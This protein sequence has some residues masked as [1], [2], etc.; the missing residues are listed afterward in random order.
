MMSPSIHSIDETRSADNDK[1]LKKS[2][3]SIAEVKS[4]KNSP[5]TKH[6]EFQ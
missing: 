2:Y 4:T 1:I 5:H 3:A 6:I